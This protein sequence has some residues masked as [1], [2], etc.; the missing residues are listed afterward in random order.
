MN[1]RRPRSPRAYKIPRINH[2][3]NPYFGR[4][5]APKKSAGFYYSLIFLFITII[6]WAYFLFASSVFQI[7]DW[8]INGLKQYNKQ[9]ITAALQNFLG[10]PFFLIFK[11]SNIFLFDK[12]SFKKELSSQFT[13]KTVEVAK[14]YPHKIIINVLEKQE[15]LAI[16]NKNKIFVLADDG[17]IIREKEGIDGWYAT[18]NGD[19]SATGTAVSAIDTEKVLADAKTKE[20]PAYLIFCDAYYNAD[21]AVIGNIYPAQKIVAIINNFAENASSRIG[22]KIKL[23]AL[24]KNQANVKIVIY[25]E[26]NW[27]IYL[28]DAD[29]GLKQFYKLYLVFNDK[30]KDLNKPLEYID[31][32]FG[33]RVYIK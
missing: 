12:D 19:V 31:L 7:T 4:H 13:F 29:D 21:N 20:L 14:Y 26:N 2:Y 32:R 3:S 33:D 11:Y 30:I 6:A 25:T 16:Y 23:A 24:Y 28:N 8:E 22:L 5:A 15:K 27:Q 9:E 10:Q 1:F 17:T 18:S